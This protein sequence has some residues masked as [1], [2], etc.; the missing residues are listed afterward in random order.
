MSFVYIFDFI[1]AIPIAPKS[2]P[3]MAVETPWFL[4]FIFLAMA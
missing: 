2:L 4:T 1:T 3:Q